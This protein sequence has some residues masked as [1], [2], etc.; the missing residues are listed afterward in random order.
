MVPMMRPVA[1]RDLGGKCPPDVAIGQN[2]P[3]DP[4]EHGLTGANDLLLVGKGV[5]GML[6]GEKVEV[7]FAQ[8]VLGTLGL[9]ADGDRGV[10]PHEAALIILEENAVGHCIEQGAKEAALLGEFAVR[11]AALEGI[12]H[13]PGEEGRVELA[14][15]QIILGAGMN[16]AQRERLIVDAAED[17]DGEILLVGEQAGESVKA[18]AIREGEVEEDEIDACVLDG[19][20]R[21]CQAVDAGSEAEFAAAFREQLGDE[22]RIAGV[23]LDEK[24]IDRAHKLGKSGSY[25]RPFKLARQSSGARFRKVA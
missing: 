14:F 23:V 18:L 3:F 20:L 25:H 16:H 19:V 15:D 24:D 6:R 5:P 13:R 21:I 11:A 9:E 7:A 22:P 10:D 8:D 17:Q 2:F 12:A 1:K 4:V